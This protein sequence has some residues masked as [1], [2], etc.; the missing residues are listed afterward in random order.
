MARHNVVTLYGYLIQDPKLFYNTSD[1]SDPERKLL[2][3]IVSVYTMRGIRDFGA[4][5]KRMRID[6]P[7][8]LSQNPSMMNKMK[9]LKKGDIIQ[10]RGALSTLDRKKNVICPHCGHTEQMDSMLTYV[11]PIFIKLEKRDVSME[12][13][14]KELRHNA[15]I[16]N[17]V[18]LI[19]KAC[20][21]PE[22]YYTEKLNRPIANYQ[23]DV[24]RKYRIKEDEES[25]RHDFPVIKSYG[26]VA[27]LDNRAINEDGFVLVDGALQTREYL[28]KYSC[29][30]CQQEFERKEFA[31]EVVPYSTEYL[32]G[33]KSMDEI[34][35]EM[36]EEEAVKAEEAAEE[37]RRRIF[38]EGE[39]SDSKDM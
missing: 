37:A 22:M 17:R 26:F 3:V 27:D 32:D 11:T 6:L 14:N 16:S 31:T 35:H 39:S 34:Q 15:E 18:M 23:L 28:K 9:D 21:K 7:L 36:E 24:Q 2:R 1:E 5:D 30:S 38:G 25:N 19:G 29:T 20:T 12:D 13:S 4:L 33:C 10:V 8:I